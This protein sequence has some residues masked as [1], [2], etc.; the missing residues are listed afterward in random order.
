MLFL[1]TDYF[2]N[3]L[4]QKRYFSNTIR[5]SNRLDLDQARHFDLGPICLQIVSA[6]DKQYAVSKLRDLGAN[7]RHIDVLYQGFAP[8]PNLECVFC[9]MDHMTISAYDF[10]SRICW[11]RLV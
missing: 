10:R 7:F 11:N 8:N 9:K 6:D 4:F 1:S 2:Q 5:E 3:Q